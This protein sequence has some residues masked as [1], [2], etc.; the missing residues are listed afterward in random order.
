MD[1]KVFWNI[2]DWADAVAQMPVQGPLPCRTALVPRERVAHVIRRELIRMGRHR[3]AHR[4]ALRGNAVCGGGGSSL[5][6]NGL[7]ARGRNSARSSA[8]GP[9]PVRTET[10][11]FPSRSA[12]F[13]AGMGRG[14]R[15]HDLRSG[16]GGLRP[17][18]LSKGSER[19]RDV[20]AIWRALRSPPATPGR[21]SGSHPEAAALLE[22]DPAAWPFQGADLSP[23]RASASQSPKRGSCA[24]SRG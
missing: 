16:G 9:V 14:L 10:R 17:S 1:A 19:L 18:D 4:D 11:S 12:A 13:E 5:G 23:P 15:L 6:R 20:A 2:R 22:R 21:S 24:P 3:C 7:Q 8:S